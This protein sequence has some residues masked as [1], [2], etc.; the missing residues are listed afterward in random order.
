MPLLLI[1]CCATLGK[2]L[3][4][5][6]PQFPHLYSGN[7]TNLMGLL[8]GVTELIHVVFSGVTGM[9]QCFINVCCYYRYLTEP[10]S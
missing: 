1:P 7:N 8:K 6:V 5:S 4:F 2:S 9:L 3:N 10:P